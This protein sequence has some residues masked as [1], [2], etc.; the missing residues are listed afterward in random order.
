MP[1]P[2]RWQ[3]CRRVARE[4]GVAPALKLLRTR[5]R[6]DAVAAVPAGEL[7]AGT[8]I[9]RE[10]DLPGGAVAFARGLPGAPAGPDLVWVRLGLSQGLLDECLR[11]LGERRSGEESLLRK[12]MIQDCLATALNGQLAVEADLLAD[13]STA[14]ARARYL[15]QLLSDVDR[16][17][18]GLLGAKG[19]LAGGPGEVADVSELLASVHEM[20]EGMT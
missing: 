10:A 3:E 9:L 8:E 1:D 19:F 16:K 14:P 5:R 20:A 2:A 18:L 6:N 15:H 17:L 4:Q 7:P 11:Y 13:G 12:Q